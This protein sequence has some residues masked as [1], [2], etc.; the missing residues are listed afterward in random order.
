MSL[1]IENVVAS[2][3]LH[4]PIDVEKVASELDSVR[5]DPSIF[6]GAAYKMDSLG[7]T[8]LIFNSGKLVCTGAKSVETIKTATMELK[9]KL[10]KMGIKFEGKP[11]ITIKNVVAAGDIGLG[12]VEL[13]EVAL[14]LPNVEY[15]PEIFPGVVYRIRNSRMTVLIFNSGKVVV[16]GAKNEGDIRK[17]VEELKRDLQK[18]ELMEEEW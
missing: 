18:Y 13:D 8:F 12:Q 4:G 2:V 7:V 10:E 11:E 6:P 14:T 9:R 1:K 17:A 5:Y 15:E 3:D 16:S